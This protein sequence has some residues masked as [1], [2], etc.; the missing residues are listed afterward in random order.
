[1]SK[2]SLSPFPDPARPALGWLLVAA[3]VVGAVPAAAEDEILIVMPTRSEVLDDV[4]RASVD[5]EVREVALEMA[6]ELRM[7]VLTERETRRA[8]RR[9]ARG[10]RCT[11][12]RC[13]LDA[14]IRMGGELLVTS[15]VKASAGQLL[16]LT[17]DLY[18]L[19][20]R[21]RKGKRRGPHSLGSR[22]ARMRTLRRLLPQAA[23]DTESLLVA[24]FLPEAAR[25]GR[26]PRR[27]P[28]RTGGHRDEE[29]DVVAGPPDAP[30]APV[31]PAPP[32]APECW[33]PSD[34]GCGYTLDG[35]SPMAP[36]AFRSLLSQLDDGFD[37]SRVD[38]VKAA[39]RHEVFTVGQVVVLLK[40]LN[41]DSNR[42]KLVRILA[43]RVVDPEHA[44]D[45]GPAFDF[46]SNRQAA[47]K[48]IYAQPH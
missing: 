10:V 36:S 32:P 24:A 37:S 6:E 27:H 7:D 25:S 4:E 35:R 8:L 23:E 42:E 20:P 26:P 14:G 38:L 45:V 18:D 1:M 40:K 11:D 9:W 34:P 13:D 3:L 17:V 47:I 48:L 12:L 33:K 21:G 5:R 22:T 2:L 19:E 43:P 15:E 29:A 31:A 41:F 44:P 30:P 28:D 39:A 16:E 46:D